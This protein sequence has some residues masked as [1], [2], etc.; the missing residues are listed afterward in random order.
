MANILLV[1]ALKKEVEQLPLPHFTIFTGVGK[2]NAAF[3]LTNYCNQ[4][5]NPDLVINYGSAG[6]AKIEIGQLVDCTRF[7]QRDMDVSGLGFEKGVTPWEQ[8]IPKILD[9]SAVSFNPIKKKLLCASGDSLVL[10][11][12]DY[13]A[14]LVDME[15]YALAKVCYFL[16]IPFIAFK[17]ISD[18]A[19]S[20]A[21][22]D[23]QKNVANGAELF[24]EQVLHY[25]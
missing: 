6:S 24:Q 18:N 4:H 3:S 22:K 2:I 7:L 20:K 17:Y 21:S 23:W 19:N 8:T 16:K 1:C 14:D 13:G 15:S 9:F 12:Q 10:D 25:L 11:A 5:Q